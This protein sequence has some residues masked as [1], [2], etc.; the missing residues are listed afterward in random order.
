MRGL[1][2]GKLGLTCLAQDAGEGELRI[3]LGSGAK[4]NLIFFCQEGD[5]CLSEEL[6]LVA[7]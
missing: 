7:P 1:L 3:G 5:H 4:M 6:L 2:L